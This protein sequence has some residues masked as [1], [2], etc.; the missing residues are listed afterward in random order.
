MNAPSTPAEAQDPSETPPP[1][2]PLWRLLFRFSF[3]Y[4]VLYAFS[5][6]M[7]FFPLGALLTSWPGPIW[8]RIVGFV[9]S[10]FFDLPQ[11]LLTRKITGSGDTTF[12]YVQLFSILVLTTLGAVLWSVLDRRRLHYRRWTPWLSASAR[13]FVGAVILFYGFGKVF[14]LQFSLPSPVRLLTQYGDSS[15]MGLAWTFMG[16]SPGY[17]MFAGLGEVIGGLLL[18]FRRTAT[19]GAL[20]LVGVMSNVVMLNLCYDIPVKL[21]SMHL[22][23]FSL[24]L[25]V[26]DRKRLTALVL[27]RAAEPMKLAPL[28]ER[29]E[30]QS[31]A[32]GIKKLAVV[33]LLGFN[34]KVAL[35]YKELDAVKPPLYGI[36]EV[37]SFVLNDEERPPLLTDEKR[38]Q[39]VI[40]YWTGRIAVQGMD[41]KI[42]RFSVELDS[43]NNTMALSGFE[44][45]AED[46]EAA[47]SFERPTPD[48]LILTGELAGDSYRITTREKDLDSFTLT[49]RG[50]RWINERPFNR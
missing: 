15:P 33:I 20:I 49:S 24:A 23:L 34:L 29:H 18:F 31:I 12:D 19:L 43:E 27:N 40:F 6:P 26:P 36:H 22:L 30:L 48:T 3:L 5:Y 1:W 44:G 4:F 46:D 13:F 47:W 41:G 7:S 32:A 35:H 2:H 45:Q 16:A 39:A 11:E 8:E 25:L 38:W 50:F 9:G 37:E 42:D 21:F 28:F 14:H 17:S 10:T